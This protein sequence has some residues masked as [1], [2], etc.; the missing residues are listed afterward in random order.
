VNLSNLENQVS[1]Y[2]NPAHTFKGTNKLRRIM[3]Q[4]LEL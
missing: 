4:E 3:E 1:I 2:P